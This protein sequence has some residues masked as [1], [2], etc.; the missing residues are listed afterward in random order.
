MS[1]RP[2][3][4]DEESLDIAK[5]FDFAGTMKALTSVSERIDSITKSVI[6]FEQR[7]NANVQDRAM[8]R[9]KRQ[10]EDA[11]RAK[12]EALEIAKQAQETE[13]AKFFTCQIVLSAE[14]QKDKVLVEALAAGRTLH[15]YNASQKGRVYGVAREPCRLL[16]M[17]IEE[18]RSVRSSYV[19]ILALTWCKRGVQAD[20]QAVFTT[21][22]R[23][24]MCDLAVL[25]SEQYSV[26]KKW[27]EEGRAKDEKDN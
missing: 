26:E 13:A 20:Y 9:V 14:E 27:R 4:S 5:E 22:N 1:K 16:S 10:A 7:V 8:K 11:E 25:E 3:A 15:E 12:K 6:D 21:K 18:K 24:Q 17:K 23:V 19:E 2:L